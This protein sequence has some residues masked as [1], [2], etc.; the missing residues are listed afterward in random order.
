MTYTD[1]LKAAAIRAFRTFLQ[2]LIPALG[3]GA[4]TELDYIGAASIAVSAALL[5]FLQGILSTLPEIDAQEALVEADMQHETDLYNFI[6]GN[7]SG[8]ETFGA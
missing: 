1:K 7:P 6:E 8:D 3:A 5:S 2:V 4:I